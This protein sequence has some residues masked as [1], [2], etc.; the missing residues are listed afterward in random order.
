MMAE[1]TLKAGVVG[2]GSLG[3]HHARI[4]TEIPG[5]ELV[6]VVDADAARA[7]EIAGRHGVKV[8]PDAASLAREIDLAT[9][10]TPTVYHEEAAAPL[11]EAGVAAL[12]EK[13]I[14]PDIETGRRLIE[15]ARKTGVPLMIGH[16]ERFNPVVARLIEQC[17]RP[18][19]LEIHRIAPFVPRSLD[20]DVILDL[21]IHDLDLCRVILGRDAVKS[22]DASGTTA[23]TDRI[24]IASVRIRFEGG[25]A[26]NLTASRISQERIR[27][28]R[29]FERG[30]YH[31]CDAMSGEVVSY[32]VLEEDGAK[33]IDEQKL[34]PPPGEPLGRELSAF[35]EA[36]RSGGEV[37]VPG[38]DGLAALEL[39]LEIRASV[40]ADLARLD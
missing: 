14:A 8:F 19:F 7:E 33:R 12:V 26:A 35:A 5:V 31:A 17:Q 25:A 24:D 23:L 39:A 4:Y 2:V 18:L 28:V 38:E 30:A 40:E 37:P 36:V 29:V 1:K 32:R 10:A 11:L 3:Q 34:A 22:F 16:T 21:M 20:V 9:V 27:R 13:P 6:G 15:L